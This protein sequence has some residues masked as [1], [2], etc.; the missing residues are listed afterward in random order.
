MV[1][2]FC[3]DCGVRKAKMNVYFHIHSSVKVLQYL[4]RPLS[5][6]HLVGFD[7]LSACLDLG[8]LYLSGSNYLLS[9]QTHLHRG[10][11]LLPLV[12]RRPSH[13]YLS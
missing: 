4:P 8:V 6:D 5:G 3:Y 13:R 7:H 2:L 10:P 1:C 11:E 12:V 9:G